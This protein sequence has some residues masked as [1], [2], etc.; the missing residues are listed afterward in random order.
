MHF[1]S[2]F[3]CQM[4][5]TSG[6]K[7]IKNWLTRLAEK[8]KHK[9][10]PARPSSQACLWSTARTGLSRK[11]GKQNHKKPKKQHQQKPRKPYT[12]HQHNPRKPKQTPHL[13]PLKTQPK[14][15]PAASAA[16]AAASWSE[17]Q[18]QPK[19]K[20]HRKKNAISVLLQWFSILKSVCFI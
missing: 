10:T 8:K 2:R 14:A 12:N 20:E 13:L 19:N 11:S 5:L 1:W 18:K 7:Y 9:T 17:D 6:K 4:C 16:A 3:V 15:A